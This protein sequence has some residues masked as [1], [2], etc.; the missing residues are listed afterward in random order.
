[1]GGSV[2][3]TGVV[4]FLGDDERSLQA[5]MEAVMATAVKIFVNRSE[6]DILK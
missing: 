4:V 1:L 3:T 2:V 5:A 6:V